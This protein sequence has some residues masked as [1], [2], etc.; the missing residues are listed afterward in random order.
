MKR[1]CR[2]FALL[3]VTLFA[4]LP[5][6]AT[7]TPATTDAPTA[8]ASSATAVPVSTAAPFSLADL[9]LNNVTPGL[10]MDAVK[11]ALGAPMSQGTETTSPATG[12]KLQDWNYDGLLVSFTDGLVSCIDTTSDAY[13]GP[14]GLRVGDSEE[15]VR[16]AFYYDV[17][18][19]HRTVLYSAGWIDSLS[20]PFP[21]CG[22]ATKWDDG[23]LYYQYL[24]PVQPY[25]ADVLAAPETYLFQKHACLTL[26]LDKET[27]TVTDLSWFV[28]AMAE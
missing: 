9:T 2:F 18:E 28:D 22:T 4:A 26:I 12:S 20:E 19:K 7:E 11:A 3:L 27:K 10:T 25:S 23:T 5:A 15:T 24:A 1:S 16:N 17:A 21:P 13:Q 14:R 6:L 8:H